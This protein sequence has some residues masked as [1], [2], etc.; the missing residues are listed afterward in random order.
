MRTIRCGLET[1][2]TYESEVNTLTNQSSARSTSATVSA[3]MILVLALSILAGIR[4][5]AQ[6]DPRTAIAVT[7]AAGNYGKLQLPAGQFIIGPN[8]SALE[9]I[10]AGRTQTLVVYGG[11]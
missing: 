5:H 6:I 2:S 1:A 10:G 8:V 11:R 7:V 4:A 3:W 9:I